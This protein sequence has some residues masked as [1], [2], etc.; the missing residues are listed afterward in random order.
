LVKPVTGGLSDTITFCNFKVQAFSN[1]TPGSADG[2]PY[3]IRFDATDGAV[4]NIMPGFG[5]V[6]DHTTVAAISMVDGAGTTTNCR[7]LDFSGFRACPDN[8]KSFEF[9]KASS[10]AAV[11]VDLKVRGCHAEV[12]GPAPAFTISGAGIYNWIVSEVAFQ[13]TTSTVKPQA[14]L[15]QANGGYIGGNSFGPNTTTASAFTAA[16]EIDAAV[17]DITIG[18]NSYNPQIGTPVKEP[19]V[20]TTPNS[21]RRRIAGPDR[22]DAIPFV[23]PAT[24]EYTHTCGAGT[25]ATGT[26][27]GAANR[28]DLFPW[29]CPSELTI[30]AVAVAVTTGVASALGK[31]ICYA[32]DAKQRPSALLFETGNLDLSAIASVEASAS[33][34]FKKGVT[35]WFGF[36]HSSTA[37]LATWALG[38]TP[39]LPSTT[40][41][42][43]ARNR[44]LRQTLT[45]ATAAPATWTYATADGVTVNPIA[46]GLKAA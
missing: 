26:Q 43:G 16:I 27:A 46:I 28:M 21:P 17:T 37:T 3:G 41:A 9:A 7:D 34:T 1:S 39:E 25:T 18:P 8:G 15:V 29:V 38:S 32:S 22:S 31:V 6:V 33:Y 24:G 5:N 19:A 10:S 13:D 20:Y 36:R 42:T 14:I 4:T 23:T 30:T 2:K 35:Y 44:V 11:W 45:Y 40:F 12:V